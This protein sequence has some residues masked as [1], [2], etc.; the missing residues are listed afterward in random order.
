MD[1]KTVSNN[2][3]ITIDLLELA[4]RL[5]AGKWLLVIATVI[6]GLI[7]FIISAFILPPQYQAEAMMYVNNTLTS[8]NG[9]GAS[10]TSGEITAAKSLLDTYVVIMESPSTL[11][12]VIDN[13]GL[14]LSQKDLKKMIS[15]SDVDATEIFK[16]TVTSSDP[17]QAKLI[18]DTIVEVLPD[19]IASIVDGSSVRVVDY[20]SLPTTKS[21]PSISKYTVIGLVIGLIIG[22]AIVTLAYMMDNTVH[23]EDYLSETFG[24]PILAVVPNAAD[25]TKGYNYY[26]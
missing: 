9:N 11:K 3:E 12:S 18:A 1:S 7:M 4:R 20:A 6:C 21:A 8:Q 25:K 24:M 19:R 17:A 15:A 2:G 13:A 5:W 10:I 16:I 26:K 14:D 22:C 23:T